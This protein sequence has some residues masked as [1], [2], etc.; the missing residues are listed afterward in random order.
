[1]VMR[2]SIFLIDGDV[3]RR[4]A[5]CH[6]LA[7]SD[8]YVEPFESAAEIAA[9]W[10]RDGAILVE[11]GAG[12]VATLIAHMA[13]EDCWLPIVCFSEAPSAKRVAQAIL[14]GAAGYLD[15]PFDAPDVVAAITAAQ[16]TARNF[17]SLKLRQ[18]RARGRVQK[19][20]P[21]EREVLSGITEGL[22]NRQIGERLDISPRTVEIHRSNMLHKVGANHTSQAI[23][24]AIEASLVA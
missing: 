12:H 6:A 9:R 5:I 17:G 21:R 8:L 11:D 16:E 22:S 19:L 23:R 10:P 3:R 15:W 2:K 1:M 13:Q 18:A 14:D 4:A 20:T 24:I 7:N